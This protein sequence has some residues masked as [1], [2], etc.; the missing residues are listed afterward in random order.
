VIHLK[1]IWP[2]LCLAGSCLA[3]GATTATDGDPGI[4]HSFT[5]L[6]KRIIAGQ[7]FTAEFYVRN[8]GAATD[9]TRLTLAIPAEMLLVRRPGLE[10]FARFDPKRRQIVYE[11]G[12]AAGWQG[13]C[14]LQLVAL[15][16]GSNQASFALRTFTPPGRHG[17]L[18]TNASIVYPPAPAILRID[19]FGVTQAGVVLLAL[20]ALTVVSV[21]ALRRKVTGWSSRAIALGMPLSVIFCLAAL[22]YFAHLAW[23]DWRI[24]FHWQEARCN[25]LDGTVQLG[26]SSSSSGRRTRYGA[27]RK[28]VFSVGYTIDGQAR[29]ALGYSGASRLS[30]SVAELDEVMR[31]LD[32]ASP[33]PCWFDPDDP[34]RVVLVPGPGGAYFFTLIPLIALALIAAFTSLP[35]ARG[36][37]RN[38]RRPS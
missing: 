20:L 16:Q 8:T 13:H 30:Y 26:S 28:P 4:A 12:L 6:P 21:L 27:T 17:A 29:H 23:Q 3:A 33:V 25:V 18:T 38:R 15:R 9:H 1:Q 2:I 31:L 34:D 35:R 32:S 19:R 10:C 7:P 37:T 5:A 11:G 24:H 22:G 36:K 14:S